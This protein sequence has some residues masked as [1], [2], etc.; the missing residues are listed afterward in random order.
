MLESAFAGSGIQQ[1]LAG[2][3]LPR[4]APPFWGWIL[5]GA[6][7][8]LIC[9]LVLHRLFSQPTAVPGRKLALAL[10]GGMMFINAL[11]NYFF[12]RSRNLFHAWLIGL[13]YSLL[14]VI[15]FTFLLGI[16]RLAAWY[17]SPYLFY[18]LYANAFG[19]HVWKL[20]PRREAGG[21]FKP[22]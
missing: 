14:A 22:G 12:F 15:L 13:P 5:I 4:Y 20:N 21:W 1:R 16:D 3:R 2:L 7:Y 11:W 10:T 6:L 8:Y 19:Y 18:L 17:L 9:F